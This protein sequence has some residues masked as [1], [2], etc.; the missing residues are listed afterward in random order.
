MR[1]FAW[2]G[3]N[4][5]L[6]SWKAVRDAESEWARHWRDFDERGAGGAFCLWQATLPAHAEAV[7]PLTAP[8]FS[9]TA[10]RFSYDP[11][12]A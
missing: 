2:N 6:Q 10:G 1:L 8:L 12:S 5:I 3:R 11:V 7:V 4:A 9:W